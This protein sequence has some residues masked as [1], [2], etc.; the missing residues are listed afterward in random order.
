MATEQADSGWADNVDYGDDDD[1][2]NN[3]DQ[4]DQDNKGDSGWADDVDYGDDDDDN[5]DDQDMIGDLD[6]S[7]D[8]DDDLPPDGGPPG[9][10]AQQ[11]QFKSEIT[12]TLQNPNKI[13]ISF[14]LQFDTKDTPGDIS[15]D[16]ETAPGLKIN[17]FQLLTA[18][19]LTQ[20]NKGLLSVLQNKICKQQRTNHK[21]KKMIIMEIQMIQS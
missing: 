20:D 9:P 13:G 11:Q 16:D 12:S 18:N 8:D 6:L 10:A 3:D 14:E 15:D 7:D 21:I 17:Q 1:N 5:D 4:M 19:Q 2:D